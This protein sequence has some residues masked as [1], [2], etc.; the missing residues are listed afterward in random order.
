MIFD[1]YTNTPLFQVHIFTTKS[2]GSK[3]DTINSDA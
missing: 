3:K 2:L 1:V